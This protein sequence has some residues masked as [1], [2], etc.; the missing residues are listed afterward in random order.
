MEPDGTILLSD[1][2][3]ADAD[4][5]ETA[6]CGEIWG[7]TIDEQGKVIARGIVRT[8]VNLLGGKRGAGKSTLVR[9]ILSEVSAK[10]DRESLYIACEESN[11]EIKLNTERIR[12]ANM[13][14]IRMLQALSGAANVAEVIAARKPCIAVID[15]LRG[16]IGPDQAAA[17]EACKLCK[18][19]AV[20]NTCPIVIIQH[21]NKDD[22]ISGSSDD[23]H[24]V[25]S[26]MT[27]FPEVGNIRLLDVEK[28]RFGQAFIGQR[29]QM[30]ARGLVA[31]PG[32]VG[33][34][35]GEEKEDDG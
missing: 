7:S 26:V 22:D 13:H 10:L 4:R 25:D 24:D 17:N 20:E 19:I 8:S 1:V 18:I 23:Q 16:L 30:T 29:F 14:Q 32:L 28:N 31:I 33:T 35:E 2:T 15:S 11:P 9:Q 6:T 27:F 12:V 3:S 34:N 21:V 5:I